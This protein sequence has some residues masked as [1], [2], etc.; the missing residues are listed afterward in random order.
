MEL[1][2]VSYIY[3]TLSM[4]FLVDLLDDI[5]LT[6]HLGDL[7]RPVTWNS[8]G[9]IQ[10]VSASSMS[11]A[12]KHRFQHRHGLISFVWAQHG[13]LETVIRDLRSYS[14]R[15]IIYLRSPMRHIWSDFSKHWDSIFLNPE[16][17]S[18]WWFPPKNCSTLFSSTVEKFHSFFAG[19]VLTVYC[20]S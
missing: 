1:A 6:G 20:S 2:L 15:A 8:T 13:P 17:S 4:R 9:R 12:M 11:I 5:E 16:G 18:K 14:E 10:L 7:W 3:W 19:C